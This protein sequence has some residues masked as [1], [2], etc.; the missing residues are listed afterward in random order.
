MRNSVVYFKPVA[1]QSAKEVSQIARELFEHV[2]KENSISIEKD[3]PLKA[4]TGQPGNVTFIRPTYFDGVIDYLE[5]LGK[6]PYFVET[7]MV[8]GPRSKESTH[9]PIAKAHGFTRL[10][11]VIADGENGD[12][13]VVV[14]VTN[15][16]HIKHALIAKQLVNQKQVIVLSHFKGHIATGFGA[17]IK[18]LGIGFSSRN[19][20]MDLHTKGY[21]S[22][23]KTIDWSESE[24]LYWG[25]EFSERVA[26]AALAA[27]NDK[28]NIYVNFALNI[29][30]DCDCD[31][32][33]MKPIYE[34]IG[35]F[36]S[37]DPVAIDKACYDVLA[38]KE[39][40]K[41]FTGEP[42][43]EYAEKLG[44]GSKTYTLKTI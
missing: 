29:T 27:I 3:I 41:P 25:D 19:G 22:S 30:K 44:L 15:G 2:V 1:N 20:K 34:N 9:R 32:E 13:D 16:K 36:A 6:S 7:N 31:G 38:Q 24:K 42:I 23:Q 17:A 14:P 5:G 26:E 8:T 18:M 12:E 35:V 21:T 10:P 4:H 28:K 37:T 11:L 40:K 33:V 39:G 43:F